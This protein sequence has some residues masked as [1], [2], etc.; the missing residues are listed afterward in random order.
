M[1][2]YTLLA[3]RRMLRRRQSELTVHEWMTYRLTVHEWMIKL[4]LFFSRTILKTFFF[5]SC[6]VPARDTD[7]YGLKRYFLRNLEIELV[8]N[9]RIHMHCLF[10]P[11]SMHNA[12]K[13]SRRSDD[14]NLCKTCM[15]HVRKWAHVDVTCLADWIKLKI[16][17]QPHPHHFIFLKPRTRLE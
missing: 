2:E 11:D 9:L 10:H 1:N 14:C 17:R 16:R 3:P 8:L 13:M 7:R 15:V 5:H 6:I 4:F 12:R